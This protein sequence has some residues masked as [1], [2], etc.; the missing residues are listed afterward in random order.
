MTTI[1]T[2]QN[3]KLLDA[4]PELVWLPVASTQTWTIG[5]PIYLNSGAATIVAEG[6]IP[7]FTAASSIAAP[8]A[9]TLIPAY[10][11]NVGSRMEVYVC[12]TSATAGAVGVAN[13]GVA[14]DWTVIGTGATLV[15]YIQLNATIDACALVVD[16][17]AN[18]EPE[19]NNTTDSPGKCIIEVLKII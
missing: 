10:R 4:N 5:T 2:G 15:A 17:A 7:Q 11:W 14:Y 8:A 13:V 16:I 18:Y 3:P 19:R 1:F 6:V 12:A 9:S